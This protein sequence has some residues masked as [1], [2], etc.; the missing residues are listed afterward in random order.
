MFSFLVA[1]VLLAVPAAAPSAAPAV[2]RASPSPSPSASPVHE[3]S[4]IGQTL[5]VGRQQNLVGTALSASTGTISQEQIS[6]RPLLRPGEVLE[7]IPGLVISQ[8]SGGGKANQYY[9]RGFQLDHGTDLDGSINGVPINLGTHAHGQG[10]SDINYLMPELVGDVEFKKG[11]YFADQGDFATAG[12]YEL[13]YRNTIVPTTSFTAGDYGYDRFFTAASPKFGAGTLLYA[14]EIAHDNGSF[15]KPDEYHR[16]NG[17]LRY[18]STKGADAFAVTGLAYSGT[19]GSTDQVPQR[20]IDQGLINRY[21]YEDPSDGGNTY[22]YALSAQYTHAAPNGSFKADVYGVTSLLNLQS[23]FTYFYDDANDYYNVTQNPVTCNGAYR[24]CTPNAGTAAAP[25]TTAY[26]SYCPANDT[27]PAGALYHSV[28]PAPFAFGC[29]DQRTQLDVRTYYGFKANRT[30]TTPGAETTL[31]AELRNDNVPTVGLFLSN[32]RV[33]YPN[34]TLSNDHVTLTAP[35]LYLAS[36]LRFGEKLRITPAVRFDALR[37]SVAAYLPG[38]SGRASESA[39]DPKFAL[40]YAPSRNQEFYFDI[41]ESYHS[42]DARG[43]VGG[44]DPQTHAAFDP[45]GAPVVTNAVLT[46]AFGEEVGYRFSNRRLTT[47]I[48]AFRLLLANE[49]QFDGDHGTTSVGGPTVRQG[50]EL[51]NYFSPTTWLTLDADLAT[52]SARFTTDPTN[53]GTGVPESLNGVVSLGATAD[54]AHYAASIRMRY[55]GPR[56]L[57][58]QGDAKSPPSTTFN[59][60]IT[61]KLAHRRSLTLDV[62]NIFNSQ[63]P[64]V[65]YYYA[66]WLKSDAANPA[67]AN[68]PAINPALGGAGVNDYHLH[69]S[70]ARTVRLTFTAAGR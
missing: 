10:Y 60:Q 9:L 63:T 37:Q 33:A 68:N 39:V 18:S 6:T 17:V 58:T 2:L 27:A 49:L 54:T 67:L 31:G 19:F 52:T 20:A 28:A 40:A 16:F 7:D 44:L 14:V 26:Q 35:S 36:Q 12:G 30:F 57:D 29:G 45:S 64:D 65:T 41:G 5:T 66:S 62:F 24:T 8:H 3:L 4:T 22:H 56:T 55:F 46:R 23:N 50:I 48:S 38:N 32:G 69:P 13:F 47:T 25:R 21:G 59:T 42:N 34:G 70:Q 43:V 53:Q 11:L 51:A 61:A 15:V 1:A